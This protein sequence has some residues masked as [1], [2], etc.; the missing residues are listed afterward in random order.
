MP[1]ERLE[2][3]RDRYF[4]YMTA[5]LNE[6]LGTR[7]HLDK[8]PPMTLVLPGFLRLLPEAMTLIALRD[9][10]DVVISCF[11][12]YLPLNPN[13][14]CFLTLE[15]TAR[16]YENDMAVWRR[17]KEI[18]ISPW[19]EV[20]YEDT[21]A[22]L[23]RESLRVLE[24]LGLPWEEGVLNYRERLK[25]KVVGSPTYEAVSQPLYTRAIG[26]WKNYQEFLEPHLSILQ[27]S[28]DAFGY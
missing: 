15:R 19:L 12:Q 2:R 14:V 9:P 3:L 18:M 22:D 17:L 26:R 27:P 4:R 6:P 8:N 23:R 7:L 5:A 21:V 24:F 16:R 11:F 28:I 20:R 1:A 10:R 13:S 25:H